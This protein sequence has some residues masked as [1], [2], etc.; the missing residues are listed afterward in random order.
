MDTAKRIEFLLSRWQR[1]QRPRLHRWDWFRIKVERTSTVYA[2]TDWWWDQTLS[3]DLSSPSAY[4]ER[5]CII[6]SIWEWIEDLTV[7]N[8]RL[9]TPAAAISILVKDELTFISPKISREK[10]RRLHRIQASH[11]FLLIRFRERQDHCLQT[12]HPVQGAR[13]I[14][15][16]S[17]L[18]HET[19]QRK[20]GWSF[21]VLRVSETPITTFEVSSPERDRSEMYLIAAIH[22]FDARKQD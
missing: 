21:P 11:R 18:Y 17:S 15:R 7:F 16:G 1:S 14:R 10:L 20:T 6:S 4:Y 22:R 9:S 19:P 13:C 3:C 8:L 2:M 5:P 12:E